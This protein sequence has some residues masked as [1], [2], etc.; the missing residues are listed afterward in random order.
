MQRADSLGVDAIKIRPDVKI[1]GAYRVLPVATAFA[2]LLSAGCAPPNGDTPTLR[3]A[4]WGGAGDDSEFYR[5]VQK[6]YDDFE[7]MHPGA[8]IRVEGIPG[9]QEY[10]SKMLLSYVAGVAPDIVTLD[11]SSAAVFIENGA[12]RDL[13][14]LISEDP[15]FSLDEYFPNVVGIARRGSKV[16][17][18]PIDFTPIVL[19]Y[20]KRLFDDA[21]VPYPQPGWD[22]ANF[23]RTAEKLTKRDAKGR[24]T[25]Y[26]LAFSN[27]MPGWIVWLWN[28]GGD[29]LSP[30]GARAEGYLDSD[31]NVEAVTF[32][33]DLVND[34]IAP[35]P[36]S[37]A[38]TGV[39]FFANGQAAMVV[40]GHWAIVSY[41]AAPKIKVEDLG[42]CSLPSNLEKSVTVM[43]EAGMAISV[44]AREP[45]LAWEY[46]KYFTSRKVQEKYNA[47]GIAVCARRDVAEA[48]ASERL[49]REFLEI[50][51]SARPPWGSRVE[52]YDFVEAVGQQAMGNILLPPDPVSKRQRN[53]RTELTK[54]A[55]RIDAYFALR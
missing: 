21:K 18:I 38:A 29:V 51:P 35:S 2:G 43:Y 5:T 48:R 32:L 6:V 41:K 33:R 31:A 19:Y 39:D 12:L 20:N 1:A 27:W 36:S 26:G 46:I 47:T 16:H 23:R 14:P 45:E 37:A 22:F 11:A 44:Q 42:V 4:N 15:D 40:T 52:G 30:D 9:S 53:V 34:G 49:E 25:Q 7:A 55:R 54:A 8:R 3:I 17:A 24:T 28:N 10:V 50:V 13:A